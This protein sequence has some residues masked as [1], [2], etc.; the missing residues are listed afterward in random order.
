MSE[1]TLSDDQQLPLRLKIAEEQYAGYVI[2]LRQQRATNLILADALSRARAAIVTA[3][4]S[5]D[6]LDGAEGELVLEYIYQ[7]LVASGMT[8]LDMW[9]MEQ[10]DAQ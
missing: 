10:D 3:I 8:T 5:E 9:G 1:L 4:T 7:V 2:A 6:G